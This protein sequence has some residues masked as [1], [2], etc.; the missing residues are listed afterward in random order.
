MPLK[1]ELSGA[2][3]VAID[4]IK[5]AGGE[6]IIKYRTPLK[7]R[8]HIHPERFTLPLKEPLP[9][10]STIYKLE[11]YRTKGRFRLP[12][13]A[14]VEYNVPD[15][16][17]KLLDENKAI[18]KENEDLSKTI[19][20]EYPVIRYPGMGADRIRKRKVPLTR[21]FKFKIDYS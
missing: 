16:A 14:T 21:E 8:E 12:Q 20:I 5:A 11:K 19:G 4:A 10:A 3:Q 13:G 15:W 9:A 7:L 2:T 17:Q 6:V 1:I 18:T